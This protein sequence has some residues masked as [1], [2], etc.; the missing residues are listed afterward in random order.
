MST[1]DQPDAITDAREQFQNGNPEAAFETLTGEVQRLQDRVH[2]LN[3]D[4]EHAVAK[5]EQLQADVTDLEANLEAKDE[6]I[7]ALQTETEQRKAA[8]ERLQDRIA[9]V[10]ADNDAL[11]A[12][13]DR[14]QDRVSHLEDE[15]DRR[16]HIEWA[17][18]DPKDLAITS[19]EA[20]NTVK[21]YRAIRDRIE[22]DT[23]ELLEERVQRLEDGEANVVVRGEF[24]GDELPIERKIAMRKA[25]G[26]LSAN[27]ARATLVFPKFGGHADTRGGSQLV[28]SSSDVR[29][30]LRETTDRSEWPNETI[31]RTMQWT[32]KLTSH[33][34][35]KHDWG[36]RDDENLLTLR[37]GRDGELEL[38]ADIDEYREYYAELEEA[39]R[40]E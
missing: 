15:L 1:S 10:E 37:R 8:N 12:E 40:H 33:R 32:A 35:E 38:V 39:Q 34:D 16:P 14:L 2:D 27:K 25:G 29:A 7:E 36:A 19:T 23:H 21:P 30:I 20:G 31:K 18:P 9:E 24:D 6:T 13:N 4:Y 3:R 17:G 28:L 11:H 26:D 5:T 22:T